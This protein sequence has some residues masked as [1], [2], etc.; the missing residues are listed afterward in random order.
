MQYLTMKETERKII[1]NGGAPFRTSSVNDPDLQAKYPDFVALKDQLVN[2][3]P[4]W[5]PIIPEWGEINGP[6]LGVAINQ[7]LTGEKTA[8]QAMQDIVD[9]VRAIMI[10][11][12]YIK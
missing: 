10:R 6:Y 5:R 4:D 3:N 2:A 12:G 11:A 1:A 7:A 8:Q 9:P